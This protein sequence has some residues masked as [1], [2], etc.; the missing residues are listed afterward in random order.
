MI[1]LALSSRSAK[2]AIRLEFSAI[3]HMLV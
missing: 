1:D 3:T 2:L